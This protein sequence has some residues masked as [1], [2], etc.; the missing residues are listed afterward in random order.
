MRDHQPTNRQQSEQQSPN[1]KLLQAIGN[2]DDNLIYDAIHDT[3]AAAVPKTA[4]PKKS[5]WYKFAGIAAVL[6]IM[7]VGAVFTNQ[8]AANQQIAATIALDVNPSIEIEVNRNQ[9]VIDVHALNNDADIVIG[10]MD[11]ENVDLDVAVNALVGSML[12]HGYLSVDQNSIMISVDSGDA[13][14]AIALQ[15]KV[16]ADIAAMLGQKQ[17]DASMITQTYH[18]TADLSK[19]AE[20]NGISAAKSALISKVLD[21]DLTDAKG[22]AYSYQRLAS[23]TV[24]ELKA[25]LES[26]HVTVNGINASGT[27]SNRSYI[28]QDAAL[29]IAYNHAGISKGSAASVSCE[30][31][32]DDGVMLYEID[33]QVDANEY[34]YEIDAI[35]GTVVHFERDIDDDYITEPNN[36]PAPTKQNN[37]AVKPITNQPNQPTV[38]NPSAS[39]SYIGEA[40]ATSIACA[41]AGVDRASVFDFSCELDLDDGKAVYEVEFE[42]KTTEYQYDIDAVTGTIIK[43]EKERND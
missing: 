25:I 26:K 7:I 6:A 17:I 15:K 40:K 39:N 16:S 34:E 31:D 37:T 41:A 23:M 2:I 3:P 33:F 38:P 36:K 32:F 27:A 4:V 8:F 42:T 5:G 30:M 13:D 35:T 29:S 1:E 18:K 10:D 19:Q 12:K 9:Q 28:G 43:S 14:T 11:L 24:N 20:A 22:N 21:S